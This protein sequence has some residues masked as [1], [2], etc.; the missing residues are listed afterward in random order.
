MLVDMS[1]ELRPAVFRDL[2][3]CLSEFLQYEEL[4]TTLKVTNTSLTCKTSARL[5]VADVV[6]VH[7]PSRPS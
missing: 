1:V 2:C 6:G 4:D 7:R 5:I 3:S